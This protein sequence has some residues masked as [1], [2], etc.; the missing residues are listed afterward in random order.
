LER[1]AR[2][3][4]CPSPGSTRCP[5]SRGAP[6]AGSPTRWRGPH[7]RAHWRRAGP[8]P[9][10]SAGTWA[11][12]RRRRRGA[13]PPRRGWSARG[14][15]APPRR[16]ASVTSAKPARHRWASARVL[17]SS[18]SSA[19][20]G[21]PAPPPPAPGPRPAR[22]RGHRTRSAQGRAPPRASPRS[23]L[24]CAS[25]SRS[26]ACLNRP[27]RA[28]GPPGTGVDQSGKGCPRFTR[29][30]SGGDGLDVPADA[31]PQLDALHRGQD[32]GEV[33][34]LGQGAVTTS[35]TITFRGRRRAP[36]PAAL[37]GL[38]SSPWL[39]AMEH[40]HPPAPRTPPRDYVLRGHG[41]PRLEGKQARTATT[42][43]APPRR[44]ARHGRCSAPRS[45]R[46]EQHSADYSAS[47]GDGPSNSD[48][49][50]WA[51]AAASVGRAQRYGRVAARVNHQLRPHLK[52]RSSD[53]SAA[54]D[55]S[56]LQV[57]APTEARGTSCR[58]AFP[59]SWT[60]G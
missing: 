49:A 35:A 20:A 38:V 1:V 2:A 32:A 41:K 4:A 51:A 3:R 7:A 55:R 57:R 45:P 10:K 19:S 33:G 37:E 11:H 31:R 5:G 50:R 29:P 34:R 28:R 60:T 14:A 6:R 13:G 21:W 22:R 40:H 24:S 8:P 39:F 26:S 48:R 12:R 36:A 15:S 54:L 56:P 18:S 42:R 46:D 17:Y 16:V 43:A 25:A 53:A 9:P 47:S 58:G 27:G 44:G 59:P 52:R 23:Y 30:P